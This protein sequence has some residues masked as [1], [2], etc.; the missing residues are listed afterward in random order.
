M[1]PQL[2]I[3]GVN[4]VLRGH[5]NPAI[6][7]P[8]WFAAQELIRQKEADTAEIQLVTPEAAI[9][10]AD[11]LQ[12]HIV[13]NRFRAGTTQEPYY[14]PLRDLVVGVFSFLSHTPVSAMGINRDFH[15]RLE[16]EKTWHEIVHRLAP[17]QYWDDLL[18]GSR[19]LR[20]EWKRPD[21]FDGY[22]RVILESPLLIQ[23]EVFLAVNDH[24]QLVKPSAG[25]NEISGILTEQWSE[26]MERS[27]RI[28]QEISYLDQ[29]PFLPAKPR[30]VKEHFKTLQKWEGVVIEVGQDTFLAKLVPIMG[31]GSEQEAEIYIDQ[32]EKEDRVLIEPG[33]VFY[34]TIGYLNKPSGTLGTSIIRFRRLPTWSKRELEAAD[35]KANELRELFDV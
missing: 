33:A 22:L 13:R 12:I 4:I 5:F 6:F 2:D 1:R 23:Y 3:Q 35:A 28:A 10:N 19:M 25:S 21:N 26:S 30:P 24:Y 16:S 31:E 8:S 34:W 27:L 32:V 29:L 9:F 11:W 7:H 18:Y 14:E 15:F 17:K 20:M